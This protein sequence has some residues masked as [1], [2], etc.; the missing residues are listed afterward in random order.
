M[1]NRVV[2]QVL[3]RLETE[4]IDVKLRPLPEEDAGENDHKSDKAI[5]DRSVLDIEIDF[6]NQVDIDQRQEDPAGVFHDPDDAENALI[7]SRVD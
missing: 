2:N 4:H 1:G 7:R 5:T 6:A 3:F